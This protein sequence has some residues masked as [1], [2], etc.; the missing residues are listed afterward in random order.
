MRR[1]AFLSGPRM[2][3]QS[4]NSVEHEKTEICEDV[5]RS[6]QNFQQKFFF[7]ISE[8]PRSAEKVKE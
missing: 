6:P 7:L 5:S 4:D 1:A 8:N 3:R 2:G